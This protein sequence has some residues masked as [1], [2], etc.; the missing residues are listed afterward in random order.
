VTLTDEQMRRRVQALPLWRG[1]RSFERLSGG[2]SNLAFK[3]TDATGAYV[4]RIGEDLPFHGVSRAREAEASRAAFKARLSPEVV[5]SES[6]MLIV[7]HIDARTYGEADVRAAIPACCTLIKT[8]HENVGRLVHGEVA[9]FWVF[10]VLRSYCDQLV[11]V[12]H[13]YAGET[14]RWTQI[15]DRLE[16]A[17]VPMPM[18]FG[19]HDL[20][21]A[22]ILDDGL[23]LWLIDWEYAAIGSPL[24]DLANLSSNC[25]FEPHH[26]EDLLASYFEAK[27]TSD[28][29]RAFVATKI[30][31]GLREALW[32]MISEIHGMSANTDYV[33]Y[34]K[35]YL[36][37]FDALWSENERVF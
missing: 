30:A 1:L 4:V 9:G 16:D 34:A 14:Y 13:R 8:C 3:V 24:F 35:R 22:N 27:L 15:V 18:V 28:V 21:P 37:R 17:Q 36:Q 20:L 11:Q 19:H 6:G 23:R 12:N 31:S 32:G 10:Q 7:R 33:A 25:G 26:D 5:Y 2:V 29:R